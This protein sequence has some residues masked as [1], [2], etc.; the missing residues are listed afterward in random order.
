MASSGKP[1]CSVNVARCRIVYV[2]K[3][4]GDS[5][6]NV[7]LEVVHVFLGELVVKG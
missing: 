2:A 6:L 3:L 5:V 7:L 1:T 4:I